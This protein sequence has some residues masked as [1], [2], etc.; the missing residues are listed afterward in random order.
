MKELF[1]P[2]TNLNPQKQ[3]YNKIKIKTYKNDKKIN[4][5]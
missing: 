1:P 2:L 3:K 5:K 4:I